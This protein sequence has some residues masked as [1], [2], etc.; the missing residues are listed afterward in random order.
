M[1]FFIKIL[2]LTSFALTFDIVSSKSFTLS[3]INGNSTELLFEIPEIE[4]K[5][6][7]DGSSKFQTSD[8]AFLNYQSFLQCFK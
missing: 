1:I 2:L 6:E 5:K 8:K 7:E 4:L 3:S